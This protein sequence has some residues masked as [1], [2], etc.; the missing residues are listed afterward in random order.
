MPRTIWKYV[1]LPGEHVPLELPRNAQFLHLH[2]QGDSE[3]GLWF[4]MDTQEP[5]VTRYFTTAETGGAAPP[6]A[7]RYL[8]T[9]HLHG[10]SLAIHVF[11][12][13][14]GGNIQHSLFQ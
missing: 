12:V 14:G 8:G 6:L 13:D 4:L 3:V 11:E 1:L 5:K 7:A 2:Q 9:A 10:G